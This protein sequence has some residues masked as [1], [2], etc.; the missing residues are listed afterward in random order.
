MPNCLIVRL[1]YFRPI[2]LA[3]NQQNRERN[4]MES[5]QIT[6][7]EKTI[8]EAKP[9][10]VNLDIKVTDTHPHTTWNPDNTPYWS[11]E[12]SEQRAQRRREREIRKILHNYQ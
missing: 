12:R 6:P 7:N 10:N 1:F 2:P 9:Y 8:P 4:I 11:H 5:D 3:L